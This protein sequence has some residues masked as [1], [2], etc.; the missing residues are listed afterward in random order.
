MNSYLIIEKV[1]HH[2]DVRVLFDDLKTALSYYFNSIYPCV[3]YKLK[4]D[5]S[6]EVA[7]EMDRKVLMQYKSKLDV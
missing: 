6:E 3:F 1:T 5:G 2:N 7:F 4:E